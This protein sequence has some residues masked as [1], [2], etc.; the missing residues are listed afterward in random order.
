MNER[1]L[2]LGQSIHNSVRKTEGW[3]LF[4]M[5]FAAHLGAMALIINWVYGRAL[6]ILWGIGIRLA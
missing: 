2:T 5:M 6:W 4:F 1:S 3:E